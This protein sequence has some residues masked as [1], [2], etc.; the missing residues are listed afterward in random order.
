MGTFARNSHFF[1]LFLLHGNPG[2][3]TE[4]MVVQ[5]LKKYGIQSADMWQS[6]LSIIQV[7]NAYLWYDSGYYTIIDF[8]EVDIRIYLPEKVILHRGR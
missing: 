6:N 1:W 2:K 7:C 4:N 5:W 3:P 8:N